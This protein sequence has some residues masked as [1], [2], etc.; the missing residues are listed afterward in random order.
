[1]LFRRWAIPFRPE[2]NWVV[3]FC[4]VEAK[5]GLVLLRRAVS[6]SVSAEGRVNSTKS[7]RF[8]AVESA[9]MSQGR[10]V[11]KVESMVRTA[12]MA[13]EAGSAGAEETAASRM[14]TISSMPA[15]TVINVLLLPVAVTVT[16][17]PSR[18]DRYELT[19]CG[20]SGAVAGVRVWIMVQRSL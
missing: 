2:L 14:V 20:R 18:S 4:R 8:W 16:L 3:M 17:P 11:A 5:S 7:G 12:G 6:G 10:T 15:H 13:T 9:A 1:M 19:C